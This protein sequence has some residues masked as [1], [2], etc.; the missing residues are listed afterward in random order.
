M[1]LTGGTRPFRGS[2][3]WWLRRPPS[4]ITNGEGEGEG[5][6][7]T[8]GEAIHLSIGRLVRFLDAPTRHHQDTE[9]HDLFNLILHNPIR[10][11][12]GDSLGLRFFTALKL[13]KKQEE[14]HEV[15][16]MVVFMTSRTDRH[17]GIASW[18]WTAREDGQILLAHTRNG[19]QKIGDPDPNDFG[20]VKRT[21][22]DAPAVILSR[23][24]RPVSCSCPGDW[25]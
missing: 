2:R 5:A 12:S 10:S 20:L 22:H 6:C 16:L 9:R 4:T 14:A 8:S 7:S 21:A 18:L 11:A 25:D 15:K 3:A 17:T 23:S 1:G 24:I 19:G 13:S